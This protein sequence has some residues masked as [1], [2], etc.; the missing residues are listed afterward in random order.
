MT[1]IVKLMQKIT[2]V[3]V[4]GFLVISIVEWLVQ[5]ETVPP[6][7]VINSTKILPHEGPSRILISSQW[8][9]ATEPSAEM[10][11]HCVEILRSELEVYPQ[12][13]LRKARLKQIVICSRLELGKRGIGG[14]CDVENGVMYLLAP[15][16]VAYDHYT[17]NAFHH[18][19]F[20]MLDFARLGCFEPDPAWEV[21]NAPNFRYGPG[22]EKAIDDSLYSIIPDPS[23][24]GF[25]NSYSTSGVAEDK[26]EVF[27][28]M[29]ENPSVLDDR[30]SLDA[31][32]RAKREAMESLLLRLS[33]EMDAT[34]WQMIRARERPGD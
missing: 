15:Q 31:I 7:C 27:A 23:F 21:L 9:N 11:L 28:Y 24:P 19:F 16:E 14:T 33:P 20:H 29:M 22:G 6:S 18:E 2:M 10:F 13:L 4:C 25:L 12:K 26:A 30:L 32:L 3:L 1:Q 34:F 17:R 5:P 8:I